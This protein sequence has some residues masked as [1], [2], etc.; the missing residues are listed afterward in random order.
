MAKE[1]T[2]PDFVVRQGQVDA[3][4]NE[5]KQMIESANKHLKKLQD[6]GMPTDL[7]T[8]K[9]ICKSDEDFKSWI[10]KAESSYVG[11]IGFIPNEERQ[12]IRKTFEDLISRTDTARNCLNGFLFNSR[13]YEPIQDEE[14]RLSFDLVKI[15]A[16]AEVKARKYFTT[17]DKKYFALLQGVEESFKKLQ[18]FE[19]IHQYVPYAGTQDFCSSLLRGFSVEWFVT[20][21]QIGK[22]SQA[23]KKMM[24]EMSDD[25]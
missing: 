2:L 16:D 8:L 13:G 25:E 18:N 9:T 23:G 12:R 24:E 5:A 11:K 1:I 7:A 21:T 17:E 20:N 19:R 15:E 10:H 6:E 14:G 22:M 3:V 4:V